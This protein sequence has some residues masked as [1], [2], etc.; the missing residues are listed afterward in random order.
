MLFRS[1]LARLGLE[2][3]IA[4]RLTPEVMCPA[5]GQG[6]LAVETRAEPDPAFRIC[7]RLDDPALWPRIRDEMRNMLGIA[8][9]VKLVEPKS[10][11]R[12][13]GKAKRVIDRREVYGS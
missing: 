2:S 5:V 6:A 1:G 7:A 9:R 12:S 10:I 13:E 3:R 4:E 11:Q 8:A